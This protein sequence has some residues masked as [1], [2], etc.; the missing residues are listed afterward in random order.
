MT[1]R[2]LSLGALALTF[3]ISACTL[4]LP[5][6]PTPFTFPTPNLTLTAMFA[7]EPT[8]TPVAPT[9]PPLEPSPSPAVSETPADALPTLPA[10]LPTDTPTIPS[11][12]PP[13]PSDTA[14]SP[15]NTPTPTGGTITLIAPSL[16]ATPT[17]PTPSLPTSTAAG[18]NTRPNGSPVTAAFL[19]SPPSIDGQLGDWSST[20]YSVDQVSFGAASWSG[21]SDLS[22]TFRIGWD[23]QNLYLAL[24]V[25]DDTHVQVSRASQLYKGDDVEI[26]LDVDLVG[27][28]HTRTMSADD[29]Q[30]GL[31]AGDFRNRLP[32]AYRWYPLASAGAQ[33]SV[34]IK[35]QKTTLGYDLEAMIPWAVLGVSPTA[36]SRYG[37]ALSLSDNDVAGRSTWQSMIS[38]PGTRRLSDPTSWG[39]L[40]LGQ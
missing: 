13:L 1:S 6:A 33:S 22:A 2:A 23:T 39:T 20:S 9:L 21:S 38:N 28:F 18:F 27:D 34:V 8:Q 19:P 14:T 10:G 17:R 7:P 31:S 3:M 12:T 37:F 11:S 32:E 26:Q 30:L 16:T 35:A 29:Y 36:G 40:V 25:T 5:A 15:A 4:P 24:S